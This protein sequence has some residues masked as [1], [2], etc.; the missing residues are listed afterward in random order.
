MSIITTKT[1][2]QKTFII[3][4]ERYRNKIKSERYYPS[5]YRKGEIAR[6]FVS[7]LTSLMYDE[8]ILSIAWMKGC[9]V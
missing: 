2:E 3:N 5:C 6:I 7:E 1:L 4:R 8:N 9:E